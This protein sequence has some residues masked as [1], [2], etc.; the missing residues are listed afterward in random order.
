MGFRKAEES[1]CANDDDD[2]ERDRT[3]STL[4]PSIACCSISLL[5]PES[6]RCLL[7]ITEVDEGDPDFSI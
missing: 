3:Y 5:T 7:L 6:E 4:L 2:A 1:F